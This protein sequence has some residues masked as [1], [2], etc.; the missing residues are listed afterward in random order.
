[1][2]VKKLNEGFYIA[3]LW[4]E[5]KQNASTGEPQQQ[6][7]K[8]IRE[9]VKSD[10]LRWKAEQPDASEF[11]K[12]VAFEIYNNALLNKRISKAVT[13]QTCA[14]W[15]NKYKNNRRLKEWILA[16]ES[17]RYLVDAICHVTRSLDQP[18]T[19]GNS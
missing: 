15:L 16:S 11:K 10:L 19:D 14:D 5:K 3:F 1:M 13:A 6:R 2:T 18:T 4:S 9:K 7:Y 17:L 8:E 12:I